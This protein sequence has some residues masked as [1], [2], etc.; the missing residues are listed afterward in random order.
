MTILGKILLQEAG[1]AL[2]VHTGP[3]EP[4]PPANPHK[5]DEL[6]LQLPNPQIHSLR[7]TA[8]GGSPCPKAWGRLSGG[9]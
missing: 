1:S 8:E 5:L 7:D 6:C 4:W 9:W 3:G 2:E